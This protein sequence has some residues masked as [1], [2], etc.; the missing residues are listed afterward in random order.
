LYLVSDSLWGGDG[1]LIQILG[2]AHDLSFRHNTGNQTGF[3]LSL[4]GEPPNAHAEFV[5]NIFALGEGV[6]GSGVGRAGGAISYF[7]PDVVW[8]HNAIPGGSWLDYFPWYTKNCW[9][10]WS[11]RSV[12]FTD[13]E[14]HDYQLTDGSKLH[15]AASDGT[16]VGV[17]YRMLNAAQTGESSSATQRT[18]PSPMP[19]DTV[20]PLPLPDGTP[21]S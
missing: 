2:G 4:D 19:T 20:A 1:R 5:D 21:T 9:F 17:N 3:M 18:S 11:M 14:N 7:L 16:D 12:G 13:L 10:P 6:F 8:H 15:D